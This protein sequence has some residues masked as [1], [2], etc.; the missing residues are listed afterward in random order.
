MP[1]S[2]GSAFNSC[3]NASSP[4]AEAP[5]PAGADVPRSVAFRHLLTRFI[6][7]CQAV[8]YAQ[9]CGIPFQVFEPNDPARVIKAYADNFA[10]TR[11]EPWTH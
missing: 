3:V 2:A 10:Y 8:A 6:A 4:P 11:K 5:T 1:V 7:T 9:K